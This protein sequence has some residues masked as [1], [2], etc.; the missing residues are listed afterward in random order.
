MRKH[1]YRKTLSK[2][3]GKILYRNKLALCEAFIV[4]IHIINIL[5]CKKITCIW[6]LNGYLSVNNG[7]LLKFRITND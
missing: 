1:A 3:W 7:L 6:F 5:Y 2:F 4:K